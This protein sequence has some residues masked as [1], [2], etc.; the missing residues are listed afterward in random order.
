MDDTNRQIVIG[1]ESACLVVVME[2]RGRMFGG[3]VRGSRVAFV[4]PQRERER[5][6]ER[7]R[8]R[9][10]AVKGADKQV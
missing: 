4:Y 1:E 5:E 9:R 2:V 7:Q 6:R 8:Q 10:K 3:C